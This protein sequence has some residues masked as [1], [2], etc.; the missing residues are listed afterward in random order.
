MI[1][2]NTELKLIYFT[3]MCVLNKKIFDLVLI[4]T[5]IKIIFNFVFF[6]LFLYISMNL[7]AFAITHFMHYIDF[8]FVSPFIHGCQ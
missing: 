4:F 3:K 6:Y 5:I 1:S 8:V 7:I 2:L